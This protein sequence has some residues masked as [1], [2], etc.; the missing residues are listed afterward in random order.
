MTVTHGHLLRAGRFSSRYVC[1]C[2]CMRACIRARVFPR[3]LS[4]EI[5]EDGS[6]TTHINYDNLNVIS[7]PRIARGVTR[8]TRATEVS[9]ST[10]R[11]YSQSP[12]I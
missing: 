6:L 5:T 11:T 2:A 8:S 10:L 9:T 12:M 4:R 7:L 3:T 1:K